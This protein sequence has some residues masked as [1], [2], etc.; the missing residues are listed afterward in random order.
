MFNIFE[1]ITKRLAEAWQSDEPS[2]RGHKYRCQCGRPVFFR[3]SLCLGCKSAL[4]YEPELAQVRA[5]E[6]GPQPDTWKIARPGGRR[7]AV[8]ALRELRL[9]GRLQLAGAGR[10][11]GDR[12]AAPAG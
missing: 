4:G 2:G 9:A 10:G 5:L 8:A 6:P 1:S 12:S 7:A 11:R 3:N